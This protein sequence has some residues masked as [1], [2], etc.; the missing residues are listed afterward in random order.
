MQRIPSGRDLGIIVG[1]GSAFLL[2]FWSSSV[3]SQPSES[4]SQPRLARFVPLDLQ[5]KTNHKSKDSFHSGRF[6][7]NNLASLPMGKQ[8]LQGITFQIGDGVIQL[9]STQLPNKPAM[10]AGIR[11]GQKFFKLHIL[12]A[13]A[14]Q[15]EPH[16]R[17]GAYTVYYGEGTSATIPIVYG[18]D[19]LDGWK[20]PGDPEPTRGEVAWQGENEGA[21][22]GV[23]TI[24]LYRTTWENPH[25]TKTVTHIDYASTM[26]NC[27]PFCV[28]ITLEKPLRARALA[29]PVTA[30]SLEQ[31]WKQL[32]GDADPA[33]QAIET[34]AGVPQ[35]A[36]PFLRA[37]L[38]TVQPA[39]TEKTIALLITQL[40]DENNSVREKA[41]RELEKLGPEALPQLRRALLK[42]RFLKLRHRLEPL[43]EELET[44]PMTG[45]QT[46]LQRTLQVLELIASTEARHL[47]Q[48]IAKGS[49][50]AWLAPEAQASLKRLEKTND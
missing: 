1:L 48:E 28:A 21:K 37:R 30:E 49:A 26:T 16:R 19:V 10:V 35:Q 45:E 36:L 38:R 5:A 33:S 17:I 29:G 11:V 13:T 42:A 6:P 39:A 43:V 18:Q 31:L 2:L 25:P 3:Q 46:R 32:A 27:A 14:Y 34:L 47:L 15:D 23:A 20:Y 41:T 9:G 7:G 50:G 4:A 22:Q 8:N 40:E 24:R 12:H 44:V